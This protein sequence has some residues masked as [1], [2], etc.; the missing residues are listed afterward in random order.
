M[1]TDLTTDSLPD[2]LAR[3]TT[4]VGAPWVL[5]IAGSTLFGY[6]AG[7]VWW[8]LFVAVIT[9]ALPMGLILAGVYASRVGDHH[10]TNRAERPLIVALILAIVFVGLAIEILVAAPRPIVG[11]TGAAAATLVVIG[12]ITTV[13]RWKVS[14]HTAVAAG[15]SVMLAAEFT[16]WWLLV[17]AVTVPAIGWSRVRLDDHTPGQVLVGALVG[18]TTASFVYTLVV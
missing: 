11:F 16:P 15:I 1:T 6:F 7:H 2:R 14:V 3:A 9:G 13:G 17:A 5:N 8:G 12:L 18:A 4:E 10:V